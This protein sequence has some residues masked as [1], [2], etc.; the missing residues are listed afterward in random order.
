MSGLRCNLRQC[1]Y[2]QLRGIILS[3]TDDLLFRAHRA[4]VDSENLSRELRIKRET[5]SKSA[6]RVRHSLALLRT[7]RE[8]IT[9]ERTVVVAENPEM[10]QAKA[11]ERD[12]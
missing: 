11:N 2:A 1:V 4:A 8:T 7:M 9:D 10:P 3:M 6:T 5:A 12:T